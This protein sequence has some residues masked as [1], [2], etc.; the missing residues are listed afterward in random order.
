MAA[1]LIGIARPIGGVA[2][3]VLGV[4]TLAPVFGASGAANAKT[5]DIVIEHFAF[6]P[7]SIEVEAGDTLVFTNRDIAPHT[8]TAANGSW[9]TRDIGS[10]K[11]ETV[12]VPA[13]GEGPYFCKYHPVMK[14]RLIIRTP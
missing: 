13:N 4:A 10:G 7:A 14:G 5:I 12:I 3:V 9:T 6:T 8:A 11:N 1:R 2:A